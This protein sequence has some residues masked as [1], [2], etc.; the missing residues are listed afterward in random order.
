MFA[1]GL[2]VSTLKRSRKNPLKGGF[3]LW[4]VANMLI[5]TNRTNTILIRTVIRHIRI[6][7]VY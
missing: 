6:N 2:A 3:F 1:N 7:F 4:I 5:D